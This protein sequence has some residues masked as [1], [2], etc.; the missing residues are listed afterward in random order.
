MP[1]VVVKVGNDGWFDIVS[2]IFIKPKAGRT[3]VRKGCSAGSNGKQS[4]T[5]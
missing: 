2:R 1:V 5:Y 4:S 3:A